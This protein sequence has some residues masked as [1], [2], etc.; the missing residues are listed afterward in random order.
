MLTRANAAAP[1][2]VPR[3]PRRRRRAS[4]SRLC[5]WRRRGNRSRRG[6]LRRPRAG[7]ADQSACPA[8][9]HA[10]G[11]GVGS[12]RVSA[13]LRRADGAGRGVGVVDR[14]PAGIAPC[15]RR[16]LALDRQ[17]GA[18]VHRGDEVPRRDP[19]RRHRAR[20]GPGAQPGDAGRGGARDV[21]D[22]SCRAL[23]GELPRSR[24]C[25]SRRS[26]SSSIRS[27]DLA[28]CGGSCAS[29]EGRKAP[30]LEGDHPRRGA[31][32][33]EAE[34]G[35]KFDPGRRRLSATPRH[36]RAGDRLALGTELR[37][38]LA[39]ARLRRKVRA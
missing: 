5:S 25:R 1:R 4:C 35:L 27:F 30:R 22:P 17:P 37:V 18:H 3:R 8:A 23:S 12:R 38:V 13:P 26:S 33:L 31:T 19:V 34:S 28:R 16:H 7:E 36:H 10:R 9:D 39:R 11:R 20:G 29:R 24:F 6:G 15:G 21:L 14:P 2:C 32:P